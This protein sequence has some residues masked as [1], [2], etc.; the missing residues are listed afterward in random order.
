MGEHYRQLSLGERVY[1][2]A[3]LELGFKAAANCR[4]LEASAVD[5]RPGIAAQWVEAAAA[6]PPKGGA[7]AASTGRLRGGSGAATCR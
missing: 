6:E 1:L 4:R 7:Q 2:Q 3:Q 5:D